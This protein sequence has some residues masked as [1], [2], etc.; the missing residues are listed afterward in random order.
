MKQH[1][2]M[3]QIQ[4]RK[5]SEARRRITEWFDS[6]PDRTYCNAHYTIT[7]NHYV[8]GIQKNK[9]GFFLFR[10]DTGGL[11]DLMYFGADVLSGIVSAMEQ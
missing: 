9:Y 11:V 2:R 7:G 8:D 4:K 6:H 3:W 10:S 1:E 5:E